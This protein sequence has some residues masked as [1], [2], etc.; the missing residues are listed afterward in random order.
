MAEGLNK[1]TYLLTTDPCC[2]QLSQGKGVLDE[3]REG[4]HTQQIDVREPRERNGGGPQERMTPGQVS[5]P[6]LNCFNQQRHP[7]DLPWAM[8]DPGQ[9]EV[10]IPELKIL[11]HSWK[12]N[13]KN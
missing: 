13:M 6:F 12:N 7:E 8:E 9:C 10:L 3:Q 11:Q 2:P 1:S 5:T 4:N